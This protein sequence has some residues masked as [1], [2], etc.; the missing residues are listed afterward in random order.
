MEHVPD[1]LGRATV[2]QPL[3]FLYRCLQLAGSLLCLAQ[4]IFSMVRHQRSPGSFGVTW[5]LKR[6]PFDDLFLSA[7]AAVPRNHFTTNCIVPK[8]HAI[9]TTNCPA[10]R[11]CCPRAFARSSPTLQSQSQQP[12]SGSNGRQLIQSL[13]LPNKFSKSCKAGPWSLLSTNS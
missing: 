6:L 9:A 2:H 13:Y 3:A 5:V 12:R 10:W 11:E 1:L 7:P 8:K 4:P